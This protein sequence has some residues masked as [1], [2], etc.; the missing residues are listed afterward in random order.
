ME[1]DSQKQCQNCQSFSPS[2]SKFC[3]YCGQ[4]YVRRLVSLQALLGEL[5]QNI[6]NIGSKL[7]RTLGALFLPGKLTTA[8][9]NGQHQR[10]ITPIRLLLLVLFFLFPC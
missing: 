7:I 5:L 9:F 4:K 8:Y 3:S 6:L 10:Y 1:Q 2:H